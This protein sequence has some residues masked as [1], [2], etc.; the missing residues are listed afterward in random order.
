MAGYTKGQAFHEIPVSAAMA[1]NPVC[2][3]SF[4]SVDTVERLMSEH[5]VRRLPVIDGQHRVVGLVS[6]NDI[7]RHAASAAKREGAHRELT[8]TMAAICQPRVRRAERVGA[9]W[10]RTQATA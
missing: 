7:A 10:H 2:C 8:R 1:R 4:D 3:H 9:G 6:L 5:Q